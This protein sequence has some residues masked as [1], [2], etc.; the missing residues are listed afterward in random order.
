MSSSKG[1]DDRQIVEILE[2][3]C[4]RLKLT[5]AQLAEKLNV[6]LPTMNRWMN[7]RSFPRGKQRREFLAVL[8]QLKESQPEVFDQVQER[9]AGLTLKRSG[10][11]RG[12]L[13]TKSME[14]MLWDAACSIR[15]E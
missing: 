13:S 10:P 15:G 9:Q 7:S 3:L 11:G 6:S 5:Q 14:Q 2:Q 8:D 4:V 1:P 12:M